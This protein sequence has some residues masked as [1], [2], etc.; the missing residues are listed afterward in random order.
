MGK[1]IV[2]GVAVCLFFA[3]A[4]RWIFFTSGAGV[5]KSDLEASETRIREV[6]GTGTLEPRVSAVLGPKIGG[7]I[8]KITV[9]EGDRVKTGDLLAQLE[10]DDLRQEVAIAESEL[11]AA[12][13]AVTRLHADLLR[14]N[15][16]LSQAKVHHHRVVELRAKSVTSQEDVD[17]AVESLAVAEAGASIAE[18]A[19]VEGQLKVTVAEK[20]LHYRQTRQNDSIIR[21]PFDGVVLRR[22]REP[23]DVVA[24]WASV[25]QL[26]STDHMWISSWVDETALSRIAAGRPA[27][28][29]FRA[30]PGIE[31]AGTVVRIGREVDRETRELTVE[32]GL[33]KLPIQWAVGQRAEVYI[34]AVQ[35][36]GSV[37]DLSVASVDT[38][39][40]LVGD[41]Q[42]TRP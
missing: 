7:L 39:V 26:A 17:K 29:V 40:S 5:A 3:G 18:A 27:R 22:V 16:V 34:S 10:D 23:G 4:F 1:L 32:V 21:A 35:R 12:T 6:L 9:D 19:I 14:A 30:E 25:L 2:L 11:A 13:A 24:P 36:V 37:G 42:D 31:Y 15:A 8:S 20:S 28:V 33:D 38:D 41:E